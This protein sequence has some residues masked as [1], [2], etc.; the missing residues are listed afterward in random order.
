MQITAV[1]I[2]I[3]HPPMSS[4]H[5][6]VLTNSLV[7]SHGYLCTSVSI[8][9]DVQQGALQSLDFSNLLRQR[10]QPASSVEDEEGKMSV[11]Q[12]S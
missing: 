1:Q 6:V 5:V 7:C 11:S 2:T 9:Q 4:L 3:I 10:A 12:A 8:E